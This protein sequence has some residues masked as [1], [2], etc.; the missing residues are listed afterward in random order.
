MI[1][2]YVHQELI[3]KLILKR[4]DQGGLFDDNGD[5]AAVEDHSSEILS[6]ATTDKEL[7][8]NHSAAQQQAAF[9]KT[10]GQSIICKTTMA[11]WMHAF[12]FVI[13][14]GRNTTS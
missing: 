10:F 3:S 4:R 8:V 11:R 12:G 6:V 5:H 2:E 7:L 14:K 9:L 13:N 1:L